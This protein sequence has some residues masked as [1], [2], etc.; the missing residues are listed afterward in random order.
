MGINRVFLPQQVLDSWLA[1]D[2]IAIDGDLL[3]I[4]AEHRQYGLRPAVRFVKEVGGG[5]D[6]QKLLGKVKE[7]AQ[8]KEMKAE[9]YMDSVLLGE[10]AYEVQQGFV[11]YPRPPMNVQQAPKAATAPGADATDQELL[12]KFLI[13]NL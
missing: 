1:T 2:K 6:A 7:P 9:H 8:L 5:G 4:L 13:E 12:T 11:G 3:T 10:A